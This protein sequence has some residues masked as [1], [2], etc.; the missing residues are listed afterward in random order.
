MIVTMARNTTGIRHQGLWP[1]RTLV[2]GP[3]GRGGGAIPAR[4]F[5]LRRRPGHRRL[6]HHRDLG[7]WGAFAMAAAPAIVQFVGGPRR[8]AGTHTPDVRDHLAE[9]DAYPIPALD[10]RGTPPASTSSRSST[11]ASCRRQ[12]RIAHKDPGIGMVGAGLVKPPENA[13]RDAVV[14][15]AEKYAVGNAFR[16]AMN[17]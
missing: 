11:R 16:A 3:R 1:G 7:N 17:G 5:R 13:F 4:G 9:H 15:F 10:F 12:H 8:R 6:G 14:A 2:H